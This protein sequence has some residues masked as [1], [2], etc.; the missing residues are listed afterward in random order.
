VWPA[1]P[2]VPSV[3]PSV[4]PTVAP[5]VVPAGVASLAPPPATPVRRRPTVVQPVLFDL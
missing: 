2:T 5:T 1:V 3:V 4:A